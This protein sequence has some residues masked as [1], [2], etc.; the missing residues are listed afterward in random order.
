MESGSRAD[1]SMPPF[2]ITQP[3]PNVNGALHVG[4]ALTFTIEDVM[5]RRER[6]LGRPTLWVPGLDHASIAA[7]VVLDK[8]LAAAG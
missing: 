6:M 4:H 3:P 8:M 1:W 5:I 2:V 7:Q